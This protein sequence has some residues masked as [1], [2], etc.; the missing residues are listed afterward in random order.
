M[1]TGYVISSCWL[2]QEGCFLLWIFWNVVL[3][4][5]LIATSKTWEAPVMAVF[6]TVQVFLTSMILGV[7]IPGIDL[8]IG[9]T[10]FLLL[11][12][13][14]PAL[15]LWKLQ[16]DFIPEE[17]NGLNARLQNYCMVITS[18]TL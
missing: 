9:S 2:N 11:R 7:I 16:P 17:G 10:P 14:M 13:A 8:K 18:S 4:L 1:R 12:E 5:I 6:A 15:E 3:G